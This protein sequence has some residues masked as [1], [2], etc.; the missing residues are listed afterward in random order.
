VFTVIEVQTSYT[1]KHSAVML[2]NNVLPVSVHQNH[3]F[4]LA[5]KH[6]MYLLF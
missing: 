2:Y 6:D 3:E 1:V 5:Y 4:I